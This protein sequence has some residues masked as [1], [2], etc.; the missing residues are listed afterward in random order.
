MVVHPGADCSVSDVHDG[1]V[2]GFRLNG[3]DCESLNTNDRLYFYIHAHVPDRN[4]HLKLAFNE[5]QAV[6]LTSNEVKVAAY[7][8]W[9]HVIVFVS[10]FFINPDILPV[11]RSRG[12]HLVLWCTET[13]YEDDKQL[14]VAPYF[15]TVIISDPLT[16]DDYRKVN[17][18]TWYLPHS[19]DPKRHKPGRPSKAWKSDLFFS[20]TGFPSRVRFFE[21]VDFDGIDVWLGGNW[22]MVEESPIYRWVKNPH[23]RKW[24]LNSE[25]IKGYR[26][27]KA[28]VNLY[29]K[30]TSES[31]THEGTA[32]GP[33]EVEMAAIGC[34]F[35]REPRPEGD[36]LFP[37]LPTFADPGDFGEKLR[38]WLK[39]DDQ[40]DEAARQARAAI[41]GHTFKAT[42]AKLLSLL[43]A[44]QALA[45]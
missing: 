40:R 20:A 11:L 44:D 38:W 35:L 6:A 16:I 28:G 3:V 34:F 30:E 10:G 33:R 42:T 27:T 5:L 43:E 14:A 21:Q 41:A 36:A 8:Y 18:R 1:L 13:P 23:G 26:S 37:M 25:N 9:P 7:D 24:M 2:D 19:F 31:C 45:A 17:P 32:L 15:D 4:G 29:R 12:H 39:H 22:Q